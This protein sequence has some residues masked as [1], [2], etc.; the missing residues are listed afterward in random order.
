[1]ESNNQFALC[2]YCLQYSLPKSIH[3]QMR[4]QTKMSLMAG[5]GFNYLPLLSYDKQCSNI[6]SLEPLLVSCIINND[7]T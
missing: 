6:A 5:K 4:G 3:K 2:Q 7:F 1:M